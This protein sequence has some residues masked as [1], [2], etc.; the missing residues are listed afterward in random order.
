MMNDLFIELD[1]FNKIKQSACFNKRS[2]MTNCYQS[3]N[4]FMQII[5]QAGRCFPTQPSTRRNSMHID[6]I[7]A[8]IAA[9]GQFHAANHDP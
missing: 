8:V 9:E 4:P 2:N 3:D 7:F 1:D 6:G 5:G